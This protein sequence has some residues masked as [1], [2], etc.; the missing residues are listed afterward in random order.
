MAASE[1]SNDQKR[2]HKKRVISAVIILV[3][4]AFGGVLLV[5]APRWIGSNFFFDNGGRYDAS[6]MSMGVI[7]QNRSDNY[8]FNEGYSTSVNCPWNMTH[9]GI[10]YFLKNGSAM[11]AAAPG[12]I[13]EISSA[14]AGATSENRY[15]ID[16]WLQF[17]QTIK[18]RYGIEMWTNISSNR[19]LQL[20]IISVKVGDWVAKGQVIG[21]FLCV[22]TSGH[23]HFDTIEKE[24]R[25]CPQKYFG[26][27]DLTELMA[28]IHGFH[29]TWNLC[30][31]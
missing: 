24:T 31:A 15:R 16:L 19:D 26:A 1:T 18:L 28:M 11:I 5:M 10:D 3:A 14:D 21:A 13:S 29:P 12:K 27:A 7:Y 30:Y 23:I 20:A 22:K 4:F 8:A 17:N 25:S 9:N 6:L 2:R